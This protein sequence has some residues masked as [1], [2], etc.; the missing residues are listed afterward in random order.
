MRQALYFKTPM[1]YSILNF[2]LLSV[3]FLFVFFL[4]FFTA[5]VKIIMSDFM[6]VFDQIFFLKFLD[7]SANCWERNFA[8]SG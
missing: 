4:V 6:M 2:Y 5:A 1:P 3:K 8:V 7:F